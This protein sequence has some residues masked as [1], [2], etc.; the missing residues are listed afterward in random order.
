MSTLNNIRRPHCYRRANGI[1]GL[2]NHLARRSSATRPTGPK[3]TGTSSATHLPLA[4]DKCSNRDRGTTTDYPLATT[5]VDEWPEYERQ[6]NRS[7]LTIANIGLARPQRRSQP[8]CNSVGTSQCALIRAAGAFLFL[9][10]PPPLR[11]VRAEVLTRTARKPNITTGLRGTEVS[12]RAD[13]G[14]SAP[15]P[16]AAERLTKLMGAARLP[17][18]YRRAQN[19]T[20]HRLHP[21]AGNHGQSRNAYKAFNETCGRI[22]GRLLID[23]PRLTISQQ[24]HH[25]SNSRPQPV[26][27]LARSGRTTR[28]WRGPNRPTIPLR[29]HQNCIRDFRYS[30]HNHGQ[31][32]LLNEPQQTQ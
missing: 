20:F 7:T 21:T 6:P 31:H 32:P 4:N 1:Q 24:A 27:E 22:C 9:D 19:H 10:T 23:Q 26:S 18:H 8:E 25:T 12:M 16:T 29:R 17:P 15:K 3:D 28:R 30:T 5:Y 14:R 2:H 11:A 13:G